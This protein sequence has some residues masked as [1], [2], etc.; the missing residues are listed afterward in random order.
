MNNM[1]LIQEYAKTIYL[2]YFSEIMEW[3]CI[4]FSLCHSGIQNRFLH[5]H[6]QIKVIQN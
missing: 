2:L 3:L 5:K 6:I 1:Y 4:L